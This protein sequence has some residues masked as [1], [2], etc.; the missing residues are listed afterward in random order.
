MKVT[1]ASR[2]KSSQ[3]PVTLDLAG[4]A[5]TVKVSDVQKAL[6]VKFPKFYPDRQRLTTEDKKPLDADKTL[7]DLGLE[8]GATIQFKDLGP[9]IGWRTVF[10]IEYGGPLL[11]H[12]IF[13]YLSKTIYGS[14]FEH[15]CMQ[16]TAFYLTLLHFLKRELETVFVHRF[17]HGTMPFFN[18]FKN[19]AHYWFLSGV[20]LAYWV[21]GPWY[22]AGQSAAARSDVYIYGC[23]A[24]WAWAQLSNFSNHVALRNLRPP[25]TRVRAIPYGYGFDLVSCPNYLFETIAWTSMCFLTTSWSAVLFNIVAT[26]QMYVWAVKKHRNYK[27]EFKEYP[28][29]RKAMFPFLA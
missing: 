1:I 3:F 12:P 11:I 17:S 27:K 24:V 8:D 28:R 18:V 22:A 25:G 29:N 14:T 4:T 6:A 15:S 9:Q 13:Y 23:I 10:L 16:K 7:A 21:Y 26:G 2:A 19:S 20:N 5:S